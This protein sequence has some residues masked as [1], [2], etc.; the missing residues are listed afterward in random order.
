[1]IVSGDGSLA[2]LPPPPASA[3]ISASVAGEK[4]TP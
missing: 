1:M 3:S 4:L 2:K